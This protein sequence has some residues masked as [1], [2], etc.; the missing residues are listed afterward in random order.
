MFEMHLIQYFEQPF[1]KSYNLLL[2]PWFNF[3]H[4]LVNF[5]NAHLHYIS[6]RFLGMGISLSFIQIWCMTIG[7]FGRSD[8]YISLVLCFPSYCR[9]PP[10]LCFSFIGRWY[11]HSWSCF[12]CVTF[13]FVIIRGIWH[14]RTFIIAHEVCCLVSRKVKPIYITSSKFSY[15]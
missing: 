5:M 6:Q 11:T 13:F 4:L 1:F 15:T 3:F 10:H 9:G 7:F 12:Q 2:A 8:V 14:I